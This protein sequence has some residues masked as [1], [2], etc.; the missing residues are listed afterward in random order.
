MKATKKELEFANSLIG[1]PMRW[2]KTLRGKSR[3]Y[4]GFVQSL[5]LVEFMTM[6][7][8]FN[9][10]EPITAWEMKMTI[11]NRESEFSLKKG[12]FTFYDL[13]ELTPHGL[14]HS[15]RRFSAKLN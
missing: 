2:T 14:N 5:E 10:S 1:R 9:V 6:G 13:K 7:F 11:T 3:T 4:E 12:T 8:D 15:L